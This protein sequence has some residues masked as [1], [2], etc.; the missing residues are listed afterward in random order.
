MIWEMGSEKMGKGQIS[1]PD[2]LFP[3]LPEKVFPDLG[4]GFSEKTVFPTGSGF[5]P[6]YQGYKPVQNGVKKK[7]GKGMAFSIKK[8]ERNGIVQI[9]QILEVSKS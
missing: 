2:F 1:F 7:N 3:F 6:P 4:K 5:V 8:W 9:L